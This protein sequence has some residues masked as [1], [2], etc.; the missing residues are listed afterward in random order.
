MIRLISLLL[1]PMVMLGPMLPHSRAGTGGT[2]SDCRSLRP[3]VHMG[4]PHVHVGG[5]HHHHSHAGRHR[6]TADHSAHRLSDQRSEDTTSASLVGNST[7]DEHESD[8]VYLG[9]LVFIVQ[10]AAP[11]G[12][13]VAAPTWASNFTIPGGRSGNGS[14]IAAPT[15]RSVTLPIYLLTSSLRL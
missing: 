9:G 7:T 2:E 12:V 14:R 1:I 6:H 15:Q 11:A 5:G 3:H 13:S 4:R 8:A 10:T